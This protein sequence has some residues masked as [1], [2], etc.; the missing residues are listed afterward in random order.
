MAS[1]MRTRGLFTFA[2][3]AALAA[4]LTTSERA[5]ACGGFWCSQT[6]P[7]EQTGE[8]IIFIQ[9]TDGTTTCVV[10]IAYQGPSEHF[11]WVLP[12]EGVPQIDV[13]AELA[14]QRLAQ[15][16]A[17]SY[18]LRTHVEGTCD[19][20]MYFPGVAGAGGAASAGPP[21]GAGGTANK[22]IDVLAEGSVGPYDYVVIKPDPS[23]A[24]PADVAIDWFKKE[25]FDV[26]GVSSDVLGPYLADGQNLIAFR[27]TKG[28]MVGSIRPVILTYNG[29]KP[30]IPIRPTAVAAQ[31]NMGVLV[32]I[33]SG[34]QAVPQN[35]RSLVINEARINWFS[36]YSSYPQVVSAAADEGGGQGF[37]TEMASSS[38][39]IAHTIFTD[40]DLMTW[41]NLNHQT[42]ADPLDL[43]WAANNSYRGWDG[44]KDAIA[45]AVTLPP[46]ASLD[47]F[48][49]DPNSFRGMPGFSV[50]A[51]VFLDKLD[52]DVVGPVRNTQA[53]VASR[54]YVT[55]LYTTMSPQEMTLDPV[56]TFNP[57]LAPISNVHI[58]DEYIE[59]HPGIQQYQAP[60]RIEL[61][62]GGTVIGTQQGTWPVNVGPANRKVV[63]LGETGS[64]D[65]VTDNT[66]MILM[67]LVNTGGSMMPPSSNMQ[68]ASSSSS[69]PTSSPTGT[70]PPSSTG[71]APH[72]SDP[73]TKGTEGTLP[74]G[75][76]DPPPPD[77]GRPS[78][79]SD[80]GGCTVAQP[81]RP[82][83]ALGLAGALAALA[84]LANRRSRRR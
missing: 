16:T 64:G 20:P 29:D 5:S 17:P 66:S 49:R 78:S 70:A 74:I 82:A 39:V 13:S 18:Q 51:Q 84:V 32:Y 1:R 69:T 71:T 28:S 38:D 44:W 54:P 65:V 8:Q 24:S 19:Q 61:P 47:T 76:Y 31:D 48:G 30:S 22:S 60:W 9:N 58:A 56:F 72:A 68:P 26:T 46:G 43:I 52:K 37:V 27:L 67:T 10:N 21:Q 4:A 62:Q 45:A 57:E 6:A 34:A 33:L 75:G 42:F 35:Y 73:P 12:V 25:G 55:R 80:S 2:G 14:F 23:L 50:N 15:Q 79:S 81:S 77:M 83:S 7:V 36:A 53:L 41:A 40:A 3:S 11:A 63:Q 59:C